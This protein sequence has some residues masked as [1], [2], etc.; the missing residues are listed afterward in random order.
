MAGIWCQGSEGSNK[1]GTRFVEVNGIKIAYL[2]R[3]EGPPLML[4]MGY[5]LSSISWPLILIEQLARRFMVITLDN[6]GTGLS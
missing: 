3:G 6:R 5:R 2:V 4:V 1:M